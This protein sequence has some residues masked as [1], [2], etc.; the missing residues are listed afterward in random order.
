MEISGDPGETHNF[1]SQRRGRGVCAMFRKVAF[2]SRPT[3]KLSDVRHRVD[4]EGRAVVSSPCQMK[5]SA[6]QCS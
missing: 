3:V 1:F 4:S 6:P 5:T 2:F